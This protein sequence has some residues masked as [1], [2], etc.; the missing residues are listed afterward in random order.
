MRAGG[1]ES[2]ASEVPYRVMDA[3]NRVAFEVDAQGRTHIYDQA[4]GG[5]G[6]TELHAFIASGQSNMS[7]RGDPISDEL[8]TPDPRIM[9]YGANRRVLETATVPLDMHD[10]P[11]GLSPATVF[12]R[13]YLRDKPSSVGVLLVP[14]AHGGT[15]FTW[16]ETSDKLTWT[17]GTAIDP[18]HALYEKSVVQA[19]EAL[20]A[21]AAS[22]Y[23]VSLRGVL[24]HQG[25]ANGGAA[26][27]TYSQYFDALAADYRA[28]MGDADLPIVVGQMMPE[29]MEANSSK[30]TVDKSHAETPARL[31]RAGFAVAPSDTA[32]FNDLAHFSRDGVVE[33]GKSF[34][35]AYQQAVLNVARGRPLRAVNLRAIRHGSTVSATWDAPLCRVTS[36]RVEFRVG[37]G[38]WVEVVREWPMY[39]YE[40]FD[41]PEGSVW[42]RVTALEGA[43]EAA[44][45]LPEPAIGA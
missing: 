38:A 11:I 25:E 20:A 29:G 36:Y 22:G 44:P 31:L 37:D 6:V 24:W 35:R 43:A 28:D 34:H 16:G 30:Y 8:D 19:Q 13:E 14:A 32:R 17:N 42:V 12:A 26:T 4:S 1:A 15:G 33:L 5:A 41:A 7:G 39:P 3:S 9:Q 10:T 2:R 40:T 45:T 21:A 18:E 27:A 23:A